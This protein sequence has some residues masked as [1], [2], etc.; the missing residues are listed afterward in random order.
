MKRVGLDDV[1]N[2]PVKKTVESSMFKKTDDLIL[3]KK[4]PGTSMYR[5]TDQLIS[6]K[7]L[8][9]PSGD[10]KSV[11][12]GKSVDSGSVI[13][14]PRRVLSLSKKSPPAARRGMRK[15]EVDTE[16]KTEESEENCKV[17]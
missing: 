9:E 15:T 4:K 6:S 11:D 5:S 1:T 13:S 2:S 7:R 17:Q 3:S 16:E 14:P 12:T 10:V 8:G